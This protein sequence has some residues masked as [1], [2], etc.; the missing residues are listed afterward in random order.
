M[1]VVAD[2][3][4][5]TLPNIGKAVD[6][7]DPEPIR[8][9][10]EAC[11][12]AG[13]RAMD[14]NSGPLT[15]NPAE[16]MTFLVR[17]VKSCV[18]LPLVLDTTNPDAMAAGLT[19]CNGRAT[20]NGVSLEPEKLKRI[21]PLA[22]QTDADLVAYLL[23]PDGHV[24][25]DAAGRMEAAVQLFAECEKAGITPDRLIFDPIVAP[26]TWQDGNRQNMA[27]LETIR[28]LPDLLGTPVRTMAGLSNL[29]TGAPDAAARKRYQQAFLPM[30]AAA[31]TD[32]ILMN[33]LD[34]DLMRT[35]EACR[36]ITAESIFSWR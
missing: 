36:N 27:V 19:A 10:A 8:Q 24:P 29:T 9:L 32:L 4:R 11:K 25:A 20:I 34:P 5:I 12:A 21:L 28:T 6:L 18:D 31:G 30:L 33:V 23:R 7:L 17:S 1:I 13:A 35:I 22:R 15:R 2:N 16:K 26:L 14:I 3:L